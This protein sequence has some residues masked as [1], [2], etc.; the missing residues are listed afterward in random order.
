MPNLHAELAALAK[1]PL[2]AGAQIAKEAMARFDAWGTLGAGYPG[3]G[4]METVSV[5][6]T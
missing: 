5:K 4:N 3:T 2:F 1:K 6:I